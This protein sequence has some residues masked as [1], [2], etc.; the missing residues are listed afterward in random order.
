M[1]KHAV[2]WLVQ[3][4][5]KTNDC[6]GDTENEQDNTDGYE[7]H[8]LESLDGT[9]K[10]Y[11]KEAI[12]LVQRITVVD[13]SDEVTS[14]DSTEEAGSADD[15]LAVLRDFTRSLCYDDFR[16]RVLL[17]Y[18][19]NHSK[20]LDLPYDKFTF[21]LVE[22]ENSVCVAEFRVNKYNLPTFYVQGCLNNPNSF[23]FNNGVNFACSIRHSRCEFAF[24][25]RKEERKHQ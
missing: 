6:E 12:P 24:L 17:L 10:E 16:R 2:E 4:A 14:R 21:D 3:A 11:K 7:E 15:V 18:D 20:N 13:T 9:L 22:M 19:L 23:H 8:P 5:K 25:H 1:R